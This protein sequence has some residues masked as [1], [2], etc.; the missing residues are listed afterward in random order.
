MNWQKKIKRKKKRKR[1]QR[2]D[3]AAGQKEYRS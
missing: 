1:K 3:G 2:G